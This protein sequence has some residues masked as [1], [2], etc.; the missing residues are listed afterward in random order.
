MYLSSPCH[1]S[2]GSRR[3]CLMRQAGSNDE[4]G[5]RTGYSTQ[6]NRRL[7]GRGVR[8]L[9]LL[10]AMAS[11]PPQ[12]SMQ[13]TIATAEAS[14]KARP[15]PPEPRPLLSRCQSWRPPTPPVSLP[16]LC[17]APPAGRARPGTRPV[18]THTITVALM[19][20]SPTL[21][22]TNAYPQRYAHP[23]RWDGC[24]A[25]FARCGDRCHASARRPAGA[26]GKGT[27]V[28]VLERRVHPEICCAPP[29]APLGRPGCT[30]G[31]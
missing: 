22:R 26:R 5:S 24:D 16:T 17:S 13:A 20:P 2:C 8:H 19:P 3:F 1:A 14:V 11:L 15:R 6:D 18:R 4:P 27:D 10:G 23:S 12:A 29:S 21:S 9:T 30:G 7:A 31:P 28:A 25:G